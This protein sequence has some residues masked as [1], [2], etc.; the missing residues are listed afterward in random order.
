MVI[1]KTL[2]VKNK[3]GLHARAAA[4]IVAVTNR[5]TALVT[6]ERD[7]IQVDGQSILGILSMACP[8]GA[9]LSVT[10]EG[11]DANDVMEALESVFNAK[12]DEE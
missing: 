6:L 7:G 2:E 4:K 8:K 12:F 5:F 1:T 11:N 10:A 3:L 9:F